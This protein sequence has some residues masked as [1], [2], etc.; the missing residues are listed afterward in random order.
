MTHDKVRQLLS[1]NQPRDHET[2]HALDAH[3]AT[4]DACTQFATLID[5]LNNE[6]LTPHVRQTMSV[7]ER[8]VLINQQL[9]PHIRTNPMNQPI[10][11][12]ATALAG[13]A[14]I[15]LFAVL[16]LTLNRP[17][18]TETAPED[19]NKTA[20]TAT[21]TPIST[22]SSI[23][24]NTV[25]ML[26]PE[27]GY[28]D[29]WE[30]GVGFNYLAQYQPL[31]YD[32]GLMQ[33]ATGDDLHNFR[34]DFEGNDAVL[35]ASTFEYDVLAERGFSAET[36][37]ATVLTEMIPLLGSQYQHEMLADITTVLH[38]DF[39]GASAHYRLQR[40][41]S[42]I[43]A[44]FEAHHILLYLPDRVLILFQAFASNNAEVARAQ[45]DYVLDSLQLV[46]YTDWKLTTMP[47]I[48]D[49]SIAYPPFWYAHDDNSKSLELSRN[50]LPS[51]E[52]GASEYPI[53]VVLYNLNR[54]VPD[55]PLAAVQAMGEQ[56]GDSYMLEAPSTLAHRPDVV[57]AIYQ[58]PGTDDYT[59]LGAVRKPPSGGPHS[60]LEV[61]ASVPEAELEAMRI[62]FERV[63]RSLRP[64][65]DP[66]F[67]PTFSEPI[68]IVEVPAVPLES[69]EDAINIALDFGKQDFKPIGGGI[70]EVLASSAEKMTYLE[71][72]NLFGRYAVAEYGGSNIIGLD[73]TVTD[74]TEVWFIAAETRWREYGTDNISERFY[75]GAV[76][77]P[78]SQVAAAGSSTSPFLSPPASRIDP[79]V[80]LIYRTEAGYFR[81]TETNSAELLTTN[82][83]SLL[84][85]SGTIAVVGDNDATYPALHVTYTDPTQNPQSYE[86]GMDS[87]VVLNWANANQ[88]LVGAGLGARH[89]QCLGTPAIY[90]FEIGELTVV[91]INASIFSPPQLLLDGT[92]AYAGED[93]IFL[94]ED[95][96]I[97]KLS[98]NPTFTGGHSTLLYPTISPDKQHLVG[99][100]LGD[101][102]GFS[103][104]YTLYDLSSQTEHAL[105]SFNPIPTDAS[106]DW[107]IAW[108]VDGTRIAIA[109]PAFPAEAA[110]HGVWVFALESSDPLLHLGANSADPLWI[111][112]DT[113]LYT[114][115]N[116][117]T[118]QRLIKQINVFTDDRYTVQIEPDVNLTLHAFV[119]R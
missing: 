66:L 83:D 40:N 75:A 119:N 112:A 10:P 73:E 29:G 6:S 114:D 1:D 81:V 3:L 91:D 43:N 107:G 110:E 60:V 23:I 4:C 25:V 99:I 11:R 94:W 48:D 35:L 41:D 97:Q 76:A 5:R 42:G 28:Y 70:V 102:N 24:S 44:E 52:R 45:L 59:L 65:H 20:E 15:I 16:A 36:H 39:K 53:F 22:P 89:C 106:L 74:D 96:N 54:T 12:F 19:P 50:E 13:V 92:F 67:T 37:P 115:T 109:P 46:D 98:I 68:S 118:Q 72:I 47:A 18:E 49:M 8:R 108:N 9:M 100:R 56:I 113:L 21:P 103:A 95:G 116:P 63:L 71:A 111:S 33:F 55:S 77:V 27:Q 38:S 86:F 34:S 64:A 104:V 117:T 30:I 31:G 58:N 32:E 2:Q 90:D 93:G 17:D 26:E 105:L 51:W 88:L 69:V 82:T 57:M 14:L 87:I 84:D 80:G 85:P 61:M 78:T 79:P 101:F 7:A 62:A